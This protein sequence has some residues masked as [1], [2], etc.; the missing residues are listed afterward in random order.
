MSDPKTRV[1]EKI[2]RQATAPVGR[3]GQHSAAGHVM[4]GVFQ[5]F[6][7]VLD[8]AREEKSE[9]RAETESNPCDGDE[10]HVRAPPPALQAV[11]LCSYRLA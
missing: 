10:R 11:Y 9:R 5:R 8:G 1:K 4:F 6:F 2:L 7:F 3:R